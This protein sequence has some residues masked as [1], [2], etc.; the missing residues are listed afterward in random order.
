MLPAAKRGPHTNGLSPPNG[1]STPVIRKLADEVCCTTSSS[2][3]GDRRRSRLSVERDDDLA[4][5]AALLDVRQRFAG[6]VERERP[7]D[8]GA[9]VAGVVEGSELAQLGAVG[10]HPQERVAHAELAGLLAD[11][12]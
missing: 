2:A 10:L 5:G 4:V 7:V 11:L 8:D 6:L 3:R 12:S 9:E 1:R